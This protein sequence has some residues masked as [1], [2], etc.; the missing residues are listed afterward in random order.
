MQVL[1]YKRSSGKNNQIKCDSTVLELSQVRLRLRILSLSTH[2]LPPAHLRHI[3]LHSVRLGYV[4][5][6]THQP[7]PVHPSMKFRLA[8]LKRFQIL[9]LSPFFSDFKIFLN[10]INYRNFEYLKI[11][12]ISEN[13]FFRWFQITKIVENLC[14]NPVIPNQNTFKHF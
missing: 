8:I 4:I 14:Y 2:L 12:A 6:L 9:A 13:L 5:T 7:H 11:R 10:F 3:T 1:N